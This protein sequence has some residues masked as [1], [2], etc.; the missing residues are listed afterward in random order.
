MVVV[1]VVVVVSEG[2][3]SVASVTPIVELVVVVGFL[4]TEKC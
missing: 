2:G 4:V 3:N 1:V